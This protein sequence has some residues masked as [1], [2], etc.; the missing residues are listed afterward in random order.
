MGA[1]E[2]NL[3]KEKLRISLLSAKKEITDFYRLDLTTYMAN[4]IAK[5]FTKQIFFLYFNTIS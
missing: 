3:F 2:L 5:K 4:Y 1:S